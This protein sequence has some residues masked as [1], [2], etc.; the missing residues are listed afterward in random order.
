M[1]EKPLIAAKSPVEVK[2]QKGKEYYWCR[3]GRSKNQPFC[4]GSHKGTGL[5]P[6]G[7]EAEDDGQAW[8]CRCKGSAN[9]PYCDGTHNM[10]AAV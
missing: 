4:D 7:F 9:A 6:L 3:C 2:L 10:S 1:S 8:L 5:E